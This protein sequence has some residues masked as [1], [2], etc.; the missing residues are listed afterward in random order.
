[1]QIL[2][3]SPARFTQI[4]YQIYSILLPDLLKSVYKFTQFSLFSQ[5]KVRKI[6]GFSPN[7][8]FVTGNNNTMVNERLPRKTK[9]LHRN[10]VKDRGTDAGETT[11]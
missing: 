7:K 6:Q 1:M 4:Y 3:K 11:M 8:S 9:P 2:L 5:R 10:A